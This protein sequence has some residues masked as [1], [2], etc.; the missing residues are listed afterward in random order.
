[1]SRQEITENHEQQ[2]R[3][4]A[5]LTVTIDGR[6]RGG[7]LA[8]VEETIAASFSFCGPLRSEISDDRAGATGRYQAIVRVVCPVAEVDDRVN[9]LRSSIAQVLRPIILSGRV[10]AGRCVINLAEVI[11][12]E[13]RPLS[14]TEIP[15]FLPRTGRTELRRVAKR[16]AKAALA[17]LAALSLS[18]CG[19]VAADDFQN[20]FYSDHKPPARYL[21]P[22]LHEIMIDFEESARA[23][24]VDDLRSEFDLRV[25][26]FTKIDR[27]R[28]ENRADDEYVKLGVCKKIS[29]AGDF[30]KF[31]KYAVINIVHPD[32]WGAIY[33][34]MNKDELSDKMVRL[35]MR[36]VV[37]HELAHCL[38][39]MDHS[40]DSFDELIGD[41]VTPV[42]KI[43]A[44]GLR[45]QAAD[46]LENTWAPMQEDL[47]RDFKASQ[48]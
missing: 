40:G 25:L 3:V 4:V 20:L 28:M 43:M 27:E 36:T 32:D 21:E 9:L 7:A 46:W 15:L 19:E 39:G 2:Q 10:P 12:S 33:R 5:E 26:K 13:R 47:F 14:R 38:L 35:N 42:P 41:R 8:A 6:I 45:L 44:T 48:K 30:H 31:K 11:D 1:M 29:P 34:G 23:S 22:E 17:A 24:G 16:V 18:A 37:F